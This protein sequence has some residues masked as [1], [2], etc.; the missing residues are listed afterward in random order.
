MRAILSG[1]W[2][3]HQLTHERK[4]DFQELRG[5]EHWR[6]YEASA[7]EL[8]DGSACS[9][10]AVSHVMFVDVSGD[11]GGT[12]S[13]APERISPVVG[14]AHVARDAVDHAG[15]TGREFVHEIW[16]ANERAGHGQEVRVA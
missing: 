12:R 4:I 13:P 7:L 14:Q 15:T 9:A 11:G 10:S 6:D 5:W 1:R 2:I 8:I 3:G 16:L